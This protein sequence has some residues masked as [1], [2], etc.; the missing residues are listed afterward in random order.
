MKLQLISQ[1]DN[2]FKFKAVE[3]CKEILEYCYI[4]KDNNTCDIYPIKV[5]HSKKI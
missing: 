2:S 1:E 3:A 4:K 5:I